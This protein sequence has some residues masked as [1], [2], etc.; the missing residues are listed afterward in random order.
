M[1]NAELM[2]SCR[3]EP[4]TCMLSKLT[5]KAM[6]AL[7]SMTKEEWVVETIQVTEEEDQLVEAKDQSLAIDVTSKDT[8][9]DI[10]TNLSQY[11]LTVNPMNTLFKTAQLY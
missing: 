3:R 11:V 8:M 9:Q 1:I 4:K 10:V 5:S 2:N 6:L 7:C